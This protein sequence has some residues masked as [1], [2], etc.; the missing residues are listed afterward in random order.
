MLPGPGFLNVDAFLIGISGSLKELLRF[1]AGDVVSFVI[2]LSVDLSMEA[3]PPPGILRA[4]SFLGD[5]M[6]LPVA[7]CATR[8]AGLGLIS[9]LG[10]LLGDNLGSCLLM[11]FP[12]L[13]P[14]LSSSLFDCNAVGSGEVLAS[15]LGMLDVMV[16]LVEVSIAEETLWFHNVLDRG[17]DMHSQQLSKSIKN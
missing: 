14:I 7:N 17:I 15:K 6:G 5:T 2:L 13:S 9:G 8:W 3:V 4:A 11:N 16:A 10:S 1:T 12:S